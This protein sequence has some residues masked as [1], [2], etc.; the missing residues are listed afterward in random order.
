MNKIKKYLK[1]LYTLK[2]IKILSYISARHLQITRN[3]N[4]QNSKSTTMKSKFKNLDKVFDGLKECN[5][6]VNK[7]GEL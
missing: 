7:S 2:Y 4:H 5:L 3:E 6:Y 1:Y